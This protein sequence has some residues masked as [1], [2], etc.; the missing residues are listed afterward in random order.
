MTTTVPSINHALAHHRAGRIAEAES[1]YRQ[2]VRLDP[3][4]ADALHLLGVVSHQRGQ[5]RVAG[6]LIERALA[7]KGQSAVYLNS[8]GAVKEGLGHLDEAAACFRRAIELRPQHAAAHFNLARVLVAQHRLEEAAAALSETVRLAP[9]MADAQNDLGNVLQR[10]GRREESE[11]AY[12]RALAL[13]PNKAAAHFNLGKLLAAQRRFADAETALQE[14]IRLNPKHPDSHAALASVHLAAQRWG[15]ARKCY[16]A[17]LELEPTRFDAWVNLGTA[18]NSLGDA[19]RA[20]AA[21]REAIRLNEDLAEAHENLASVLELEGRIDEGLTHY[22]RAYRLKGGEEIRIREA[23]ALP[24]VYKSLDDL[25]AHR[26][27]MIGSVDRLVE[28]GVCVDPASTSVSPPF[29]LAYQGFNDRPLLEQIARLF[30]HDTTTVSRHGPSGSQGDGRVHLGI[31][32]RFLYNHT[33]GQF[34]AGMIA[35]LPR[36]RFRISVFSG[37][38]RDDQVSRFVRAKADDYVRL[39]G[40]V[41]NARRQ[42]QAAELDV[43]YY[44]EIGMDPTTYALAPYRLAPVQCVGWG[45]P[46]TTGLASIDYFLSSEMVE[47]PEADDHYTERLVR[48]AHLPTYYHRPSEPGRG[49]RADFGLPDDRPLYVCPQNL[50]KFHPEFDGLLAALLGRDTRGVLVLVEGKY[51]YW[52]KLLRTRLAEALGEA[53]QRVIFVPRQPL[54][55][56][57]GL[58]SVCD[59]MLDPLHFGGGNT[60]YQAL[61]CGLPV[62][63]LPSGLMRGRVTLGLYRQMGQTECVADSPED[64]VEK[65]VRLANDRRFRHDVVQQLSDAAHHVFEDRRAVDEMADFLE[66]AVLS[67]GLRESADTNPGGQR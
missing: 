8:L 56:F 6:E 63:T 67:G 1:I 27:R 32:S 21:F 3:A 62:V 47:P 16:E 20:A 49:G 15:D 46:I 31:L 53:I 5:H 48:L 17:A 24:P 9:E 54:L 58:L 2:I 26:A 7:A 11:T 41:A 10:L 34:T 44:P 45:H 13:E 51:D 65:A 64:Y 66:R 36:E 50:F 25:N 39:D 60:S 35:S 33:I 23:L 4:H 52:S 37:A 38:R 22:R 55:G 19:Q 57:L 42:L 40:S 30:Q 61:A 12:R 43:L 29:F 59:V 28:E 14:A 18:L